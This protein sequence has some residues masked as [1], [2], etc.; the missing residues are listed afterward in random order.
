MRESNIV[1]DDESKLN[2]MVH[3]V[4]V[5]ETGCEVTNENLDPTDPNNKL[6][7]SSN[8]N[9]RIDNINGL[10][11]IDSLGIKPDSDGTLSQKNKEKA[12]KILGLIRSS[13][14]YRTD[15]SKMI[16]DIAE[17]LEIDDISR[18]K[19]NFIYKNSYKLDK[20]NSSGFMK[21]FKSA[22]E[23]LL[24]IFNKDG[25]RKALVTPR[26]QTIGVEIFI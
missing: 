1:N 16:E 24:G 10:L 12:L 22:K 7:I 11:K 25:S 13:A 18:I 19:V 8:A 9:Q 3:T 17:A 5:Q 26:R 23:I 20:V 2:M 21:F 4:M 6:L 14:I 15:K